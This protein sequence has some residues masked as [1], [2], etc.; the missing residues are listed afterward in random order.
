MAGAID[1]W[2]E[3]MPA[4]FIIITPRATKLRV[5]KTRPGYLLAGFLGVSPGWDGIFTVKRD[6]SSGV[7]NYV[8]NPADYL[9]AGTAWSSQSAAD[10]VVRS[11]TARRRSG[12][13]VGGCTSAHR[14]VRAASRN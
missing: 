14:A 8:A 7:R 12:L 5:E 4:M 11:R 10:F 13:P 9:I 6:P 1:P 2:A 3:I